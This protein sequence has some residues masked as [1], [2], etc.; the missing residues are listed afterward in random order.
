MYVVG[1]LGLLCTFGC[2]CNL[3]EAA[4]AAEFPHITGFEWE[5]L[6][7]GPGLAHLD[8]MIERE[9]GTLRIYDISALTGSRSALMNH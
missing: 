1:L 3:Q 6:T 4:L 2:D 5:F 8:E 7:E 9:A